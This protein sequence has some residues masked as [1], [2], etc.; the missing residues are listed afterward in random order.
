MSLLK[1]LQEGYRMDKPN[2]AA[3]SE[4]RKLTK[5][6]LIYGYNCNPIHYTVLNDSIFHFLSNYR[7]ESVILLCW[8][9]SPEERPTFSELVVIIENML[10]SMANYIDFNQFMLVVEEQKG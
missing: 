2:N 1:L 4:K 6:A 8:N 9:S 5:L 7:Y 3:C 10:T